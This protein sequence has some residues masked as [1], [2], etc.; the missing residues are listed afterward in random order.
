MPENTSQKRVLI[1]RA[2]RSMFISIVVASALLIF[3]IVSIY[4]LSKVYSHR[5][6]VISEKKNS[7]KN[8]YSQ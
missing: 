7:I 8:T 5:S 6:K 2:N 3:A 1:D 4:S